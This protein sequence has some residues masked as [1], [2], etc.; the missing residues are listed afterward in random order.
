[1]QAL[2]TTVKEAKACL[3]IHLM[4]TL[5]QKNEEK[6]HTSLSLCHYETC[7]ANEMLNE[8]DSH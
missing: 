3:Y 4:L 8:N 1:M 2:E 6:L 7:L 5:S